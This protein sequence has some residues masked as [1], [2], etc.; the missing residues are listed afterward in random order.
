M[1]QIVRI[2]TPIPIAPPQRTSAG[3]ESLSTVTAAAM[4]DQH[5]G[6]RLDPAERTRIGERVGSR[7][8]RG[9]F[10]LRLHRE[11][12]ARRAGTEP[13][14]RGPLRRAL[15]RQRQDAGMPRPQDGP[16]LLRASSK[17]RAAA[18]SPTWWPTGSACCWSASTPASGRRGA[19]TTSPGPATAS[20]PPSTPPASRRACWTRP[21]S[22]SSWRSASGSR[23][24][25]RGPR[26]PRT[27]SRA[28]RSG[29]AASAWR[30]SSP[31]SGWRPWRSSGWA[32]TAPPSA[33][34]ARRSGASP[35][36]W[37]APWSG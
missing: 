34:R 12:L 23:T 13:A 19:G 20:G 32:R 16:A 10:R 14:S 26:P 11:R 3:R 2:S 17:R 1:S 21:R 30:R 4:R 9:S 31:G 36:R 6:G 15:A 37:P 35:R 18:W 8:S 33:A 27:S 25:C 7:S 28:T 24:W 29:R 5:R 22:A